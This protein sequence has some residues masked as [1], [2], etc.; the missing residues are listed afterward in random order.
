[1]TSRHHDIEYIPL[2][3]S[4]PGD[5]PHAPRR[6]FASAKYAG[7]LF[8]AA[9]FFA[10]VFVGGGVGRWAT[11]PDVTAYIPSTV[12]ANPVRFTPVVTVF[13]SFV[14]LYVSSSFP[15]DELLNSSQ[16]PRFPGSAPQLDH[17]QTR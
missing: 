9:V 10:G 12:T 11:I 8:L 17:N 13:D 1:M 2:D 3:S 15:P 16:K 6:S 5:P 14:D 7:H 4:D